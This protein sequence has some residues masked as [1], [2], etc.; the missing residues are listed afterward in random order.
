MVEQ[1]YRVITL[2]G[3]YVT[4][5]WIQLG[6]I[7]RIFHASEITAY[8]SDIISKRHSDSHRTE[9]QVWRTVGEKCFVSVQKHF[10][11]SSV[12]L[13]GWFLNLW[14]IVC[15]WLIRCLMSDKNHGGCW[16]A[17]NLLKGMNCLIPLI[18]ACQMMC[19]IYSRLWDKKQQMKWSCDILTKVNIISSRITEIVESFTFTRTST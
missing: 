5:F 14:L 6:T 17:W 9:A 1:G 12:G 18:I 10:D 4:S 7:L 2:N 19:H 13:V 16:C 8:L 11:L 15:R 3:T